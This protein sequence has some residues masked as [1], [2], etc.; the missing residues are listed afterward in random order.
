[1][2]FI[3][4]TPKP[5]YITGGGGTVSLEMLVF[6]IGIASPVDSVTGISANARVVQCLI[7]IIAAYSV[8]AT[9]QVGNTVTA[10]LIHG[11]PFV[12]PQLANDYYN[13][14]CT[15]WPINSVVRCTIGGAPVAGSGIVMVIY[16]TPNT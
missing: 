4:V 11:A 5:I 15:L 3:P 8:G 1:M 9:I 12:N 7:K 2:S 14:Q 13:I 10:N 16:G 6:S